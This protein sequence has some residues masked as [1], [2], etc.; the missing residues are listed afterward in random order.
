M[1]KDSDLEF[2]RYEIKFTVQRQNFYFLKNWLLLNPHD[3]YIPYPSR[4]VNNIYFDNQEYDSYVENLT[5]CTS[6]T[7][8]RLRWYGD[9]FDPENAVLEVKAKRNRLGFKGAHKIMFEGMKMSKMSYSDIVK[10]IKRQIEGD[11]YF[12][13]QQSDVPIIIN[14]YERE[15]FITR[16]RKIRATLD[17]NLTFYDQRNRLKP[18]STFKSLSPEISI[19]E[20]KAPSLEIDCAEKV[21]ETIQ[22]PPSKSSKYVLGVQSLIGYQ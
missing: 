14:R 6:R 12:R 10:N 18:N 3:F 8:I 1:I 9:T 20:I 7:K 5:G 16:N 19:F 11:I 21:I 17:A 13:F 15:Y 22:L 2:A 4:I